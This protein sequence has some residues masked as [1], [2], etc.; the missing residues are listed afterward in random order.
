VVVKRLVVFSSRNSP[1]DD[2]E[3]AMTVASQLPR[4]TT[5]APSRAVLYGLLAVAALSVGGAVISVASGLS[6]SLLD[7]MGPHGR[8]SIP[9]PM[10]VA[11]VAL[12]FAAGSPRRAVALIGSGLLAAALL[13]GV[14]SGFFDGG[15]ADDRLTAVERVYQVTFVG[16]LAVVGVMAAR[17]FWQVLRSTSA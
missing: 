9:L 15:Y 10:M 14:V 4:V 17:R 5:V 2:K 7:A 13:A 3:R 12:A 11:Q 16:T 6:P 1:K 8:L